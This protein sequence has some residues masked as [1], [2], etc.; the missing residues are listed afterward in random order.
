MSLRREIR[1]SGSRALSNDTPVNKYV[2]KEAGNHLVDLHGQHD[3]QQLLDEENHL[4]VIDQFE[5]VQPALKAYSKEY[6]KML[7][8]QKELRNLK[9]REAELREKTE[10]YQFQVKE[11]ED[12]QLDIEEEEAL[13]AEMNLLDNA[14]ELDQKASAIDRK[15]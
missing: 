13:I 6:Q 3:H 10:L 5:S 1:Q 15:S 8:L 7:A 12:A 2:M 11:I 4:G 9:K 14:E